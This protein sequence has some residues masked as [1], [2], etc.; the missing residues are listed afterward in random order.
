MT[1]TIPYRLGR[2]T[3]KRAPALR[4]ADVVVPGVPHPAAADYL[5]LVTDWCLCGNDRFGD[6]GPVA[7]DNDRRLV[8]S[9]LSDGVPAYPALDD[10]YDLYR[11]S[12]NPAFSPDN[13]P[14]AAGDDGVDVQ[15]MCEALVTG[16]FGGVRAVAFAQV[17]HTDPEA[18]RAAVAVFGSVLLG[19]NL[20]QAQ[21]GQTPD[22]VWDGVPGSPAWGGHAVLAG[23]YNLDFVEV[24]TWGRRVRCT[25]AFLASQ[26][27][28][29]WVV[30]WPEHLGSRRFAESVDLVALAA[31]YLAL[32][33][34]ALPLPPPPPGLAPCVDDADRALAA[35]LVGWETWRHV[36]AARRVARA[37]ADWRAAKKI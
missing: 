21:R 10:V 3:P 2:R 18:V 13:P 9:A 12:G 26:L 5:R 30:V 16:G 11:R 33:G 27:D 28:E 6:C 7:V 35:A 1:Q 8:T 19:V 22:G 25:N 15:T 20:T 37:L 23:S 31:D 14:G 4:L 36:G 17:D 29:A 32:T 24:V 34:G